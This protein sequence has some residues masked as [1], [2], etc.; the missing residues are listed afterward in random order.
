MVKC[1][2]EGVEANVRLRNG[3]TPLMLANRASI[4]KK[5]IAAGA[6]INEV[7]DAGRTPL[8]WFCLGSYPTRNADAYIRYL[9]G[10]GAATNVIDKEGRTAHE[11]A[12]GKCSSDVLEMLREL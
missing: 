7:D 8:I 2:A 11:Y 4:A 1:L 12:K 5:L 6:N 3:L 10:S 9:I